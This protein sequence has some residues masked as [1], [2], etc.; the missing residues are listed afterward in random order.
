MSCR[1]RKSSFYIEYVFV[2]IQ[3][4]SGLFCVAI[5]P[6]KRYPI[7][8][9]ATVKLYLGKRRTEVSEYSAL[10]TWIG[11]DLCPSIGRLFTKYTKKI[12]NV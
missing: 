11:L 2:I 1:T 4:Y 8:T 9:N 10:K 12:Y 7:Y 3:T 5:N 6:Y